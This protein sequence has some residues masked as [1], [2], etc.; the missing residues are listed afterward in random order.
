MGVVSDYYDITIGKTPPRK[1]KQWFS[2]NEKEINR[3]AT[4]GISF[5]ER[6]YSYRSWVHS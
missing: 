2:F 6:L 5:Y 3:K 1:E 4:E